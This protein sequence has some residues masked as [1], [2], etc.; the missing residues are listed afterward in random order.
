MSF[1]RQARMSQASKNERYLWRTFYPNWSNV[2]KHKV[3]DFTTSSLFSISHDDYV[4]D[5][6]WENKSSIFIEGG[7]IFCSNPY[8]Q[9]I[10]ISDNFKEDLRQGIY[11]HLKQFSL[12]DLT[13]DDIA[14][15]SLYMVDITRTRE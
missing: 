5:R 9:K 12:K 11:P 8:N 1:Y 3:I 14:D 10:S 15:V 6:S 2:Y 7:M 4:L 13:L